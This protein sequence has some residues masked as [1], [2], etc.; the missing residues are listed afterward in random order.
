MREITIS[1][2]D[3]RIDIIQEW[4]GKAGLALAGFYDPNRRVFWRESPHPEKRDSGY[5]ATSTNRAF[6]AMCEYLRFLE[7]DDKGNRVN[8]EGIEN[9]LKTLKGIAEGY[10]ALAPT[11]LD[12]ILTSRT[13]ARNMF[14]DSQFLTSVSL[15]EHLVK[16]TD[17][18]R[19]DLKATRIA[20]EEVAIRTKNDLEASIGG[21]FTGADE[22]HD[23]VT[24][25][26]VRGLDAFGSPNLYKSVGFPQRLSARIKDTI[27]DL[28]AFHFAGVSSRFD[29]VE[30]TFSIALLNRFPTP[31][32]IPLTDRAIRSIAEAQ[33]DDGSWPVTRSVSYASKKHLH[34]TSYEIALTLT[35]L[36][37]RKVIE[38]SL[39][40][41]G[42]IYPC[43]VKAFELVISYYNEIN[44]ARGW[45]NDQTRRK[46]MLESW[47]TAIVLTFLIHLHDAFICLRQALILKKYERII[48]AKALAVKPWP[49]MIPSMRSRVSIQREFINEISDPTD[50]GQLTSQIKQQIIDPIAYDW[51]QRPTRS[52]L[53]FYGPPGTRKTSMAIAV[54][55]AIGWPVLIFYPPHFLRRGGL[56]GFEAAADEIFNDLLRLRR[57]VVLF[58]ECE[59]FFKKRIVDTQLGSRTIGAFITAGMLPRLQLLRETRW[60]VFILCTNSEL[61]ELD[62]AVTRRGRF[63]YVQ[64]I[65]L[66]TPSAQVAYVKKR[67]KEASNVLEASVLDALRDFY[68]NV[69]SRKLSS[70]TSFALLDDLIE[71]VIVDWRGG[72]EVD[73]AEVLRLLIEL[74]EYP[75]PKCLA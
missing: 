71:T 40:L 31:D 44:E 14:T 25:H 3:N 46:G 75:G 29:P 62:P 1:E 5:H 68:S 67:L 48:D 41:C 9:A 39:D 26:A 52:S 13:N 35:N 74:A 8:R 42:L 4:I 16:Y 2:L 11:K 19:V 54:G 51:I 32:V 7:E 6:H 43:L 21:K 22:V 56:D 69:E 18:M 23:F 33:S 73:S 24:L 58:D 59:E 49:D 55:K 61:D 60:V 20:A 66:P 36:F 28:L 38:G 45:V 47:A 63:D 10:I 27:L 53:L 72:K 57:V 50:G 15:L 12:E 64:E 34:I 65:A 37:I 30:L 70:D 17:R